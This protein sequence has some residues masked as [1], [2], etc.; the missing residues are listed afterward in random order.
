MELSSPLSSPPASKSYEKA[1]VIDV[2]SYK[3]Y[4]FIPHDK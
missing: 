3:D 1:V 2:I 4:V